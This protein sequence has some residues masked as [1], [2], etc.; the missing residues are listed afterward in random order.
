MFHLD[1]AYFIPELDFEGV[2]VQTNLA[3]N[4][5]FRGFGGPQ[6]MVVIEAAISEVRRAPR[7]VDPAKVRAR[8]F[9]GDGDRTPVRAGRTDASRA[10][11]GRIC[12]AP[13]ATT[14]ADAEIAALNQESRFVRAA[15]PCSR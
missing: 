3:S 4:T 15:S 6:G 13:P 5:A 8:N 10:D 1:N 2:V 7:P 14:S 12:C 11:L 9:Y